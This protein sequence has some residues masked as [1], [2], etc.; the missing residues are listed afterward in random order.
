MIIIGALVSAFCLYLSDVDQKLLDEGTRTEGVVTSVN[1]KS[2]KSSKKSSNPKKIITV[3][4]KDAHEKSHTTEY[5]ENYLANGQSRSEQANSDKG[6]TVVVFY[7]PSF[8]DHAVVEGK[9]I[10]S[11]LGYIIAAIFLFIAIC[12]TISPLISIRQH[13]KTRN[14]NA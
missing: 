9:E 10:D 2:V 14:Q 11:A 7:D 13:R 8:P 4:Y 1:Y 5:S 12:T 6:K 3:S